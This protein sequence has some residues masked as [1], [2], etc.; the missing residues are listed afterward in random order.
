VTA[1]PRLASPEARDAFP[2]L[3][4]PSVRHTG[5]PGGFSWFAKPAS[6]YDSILLGREDIL[7][8]WG[9]LWKDDGSI[10]A[11]LQNFE[12]TYPRLTPTGRIRRVKPSWFHRLNA[13]EDRPET[14]AKYVLPPKKGTR[15]RKLPALTMDERAGAGLNGVLVECGCEVR[16]RVPRAHLEWRCMCC[17]NYRKPVLA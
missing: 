5:G 9:F 8:A 15:G 7:R 14:D 13:M 1:S 4:P 6:E 2:T 16:F 10:E 11:L 3:A 17:G 12:E